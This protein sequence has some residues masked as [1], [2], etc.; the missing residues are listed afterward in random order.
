MGPQRK[1]EKEKELA[2]DPLEGSYRPSVLKLWCLKS[3]W[4]LKLVIDGRFPANP[5]IDIQ[6]FHW[7]P[8]DWAFIGFFRTMIL[9][10]C[11]YQE[12][13]SQWL[14]IYYW[15]QCLIV[16]LTISA[17]AVRFVSS[18]YLSQSDRFFYGFFLSIFTVN[19]WM[20]MLLLC[21]CNFFIFTFSP[22]YFTDLHLTFLHR[23]PQSAV[24][25]GERSDASAIQ[26]KHLPL[27]NLMF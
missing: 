15:C 13:C 5:R 7:I 20:G 4:T 6:Y 16:H 21:C 3:I 17:E 19:D 23:A 2:C 14:H 8:E 27:I 26:N 12:P 10:L 25:D 22:K 1:K 18:N 24:T 9:I 11:L